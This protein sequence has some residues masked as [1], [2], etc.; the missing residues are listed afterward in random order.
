MADASSTPVAGGT[1]ATM[2]KGALSQVDV[3][4][5][6]NQALQAKNRRI[7]VCGLSRNSPRRPTT[8]LSLATPPS[9]AEQDRQLLQNR[10]NRLIVEE[11]KAAKRIAETRRRAKEIWELKRRNEASQ[12]T[13][14]DA[15]A[16]MSA[17]QELQKELMRAAR[18]ERQAGIQASRGA[19]AHMR[20][21]EV[22]VL[23]QMRHE[24]EGAV[25]AQRAFEHGRAVQRK[26]MVKEQ[27]RLAAERKAKER[28]AALTRLKAEREAKQSLLGK[29]ASDQ[30][31]DFERMEEEERRLIASLQATQAQQ[32]AAYSELEGVLGS[33]QASRV[34]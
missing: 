27:Q 23:R 14:Q 8:H 10:I 16:W 22:K 18:S 17:E 34:R 4:S 2:P 29:D 15:G 12:A 19:M 9:Q 33:A 1:V 24:N 11:E 21:E 7:K 5:I 20:R 13:R 32:Q 28:E 25:Q 30:V 31:R 6:G 3:D 26:A